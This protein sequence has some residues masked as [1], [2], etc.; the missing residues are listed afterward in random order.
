MNKD[1]YV[2]S[3]AVVNLQYKFLS[4]DTLLYMEIHNRK[5]K[6]RGKRKEK[7]VSKPILENIYLI[8]IRI[9]YILFWDL[10]NIHNPTIILME[11]WCGFSVFRMVYKCRKK[12]KKIVYKLLVG[13]SAW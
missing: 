4:Y 5:M 7:N 12:I 1:K 10:K 9:F 13:K 6:S 3:D 8:Y 11:K 2:T